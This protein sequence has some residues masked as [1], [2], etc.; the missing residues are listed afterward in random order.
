MC[1]AWQRVVIIH[2]IR[3]GVNL[4]FLLPHEIRHRAALSPEKL[5]WLT[6][7]LAL[8]LCAHFFTVDS[9]PKALSQATASPSLCGGASLDDRR[10]LPRP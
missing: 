8:E 4:D 2:L 3:R 1:I 5:F 9:F 7:D 6:K 10:K